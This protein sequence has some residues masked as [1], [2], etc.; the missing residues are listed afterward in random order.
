MKA[1]EFSGVCFSYGESERPAIEKLDLSVE[2][3]EF[4]AL[5]GH[6]G[7]GKSTLARLANGLLTAD[8][9]QISVF[10]RPIDGKNLFGI[11]RDVGVVFQNPDSQAVAS[12]VEDD[13]AFGAENV[14]L[15]R[16]EI[17]DR[18]G[19]ALR[20][21]GM[22]EFRTATIARL[23]GGQ[24]QRIAIAGVLALRPRIMILDE[25]TAMLD[26]RGRREIVEVVKK[27]NEEGITVLMITHFMEEALLASRAVVMNCG[28]VAMEGTPSEI[29]E[30]HEE[31]LKYNLVL[32]RIGYL[33]RRLREGGIRVS[34]TLDIGTLA[35]EIASCVS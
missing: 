32:P 14:G 6:N 15:P 24:K 23:S 2:E 8:S 27:L 18:I 1:L 12:I 34:D 13:V 26:P 7:S 17:G 4:V 21:V 28:T 19:F 31:L 3:G 33:C 30:R 10:G 11:R 16:E 22:E 35:K 25:A 29:F 5:L 9:G 20:A